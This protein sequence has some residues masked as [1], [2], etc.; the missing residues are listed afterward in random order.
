MFFGYYTLSK[1]KMEE[2]R[3]IFSGKDGQMTACEGS[4]LYFSTNI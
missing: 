2:G 4:F 1:G 3:G